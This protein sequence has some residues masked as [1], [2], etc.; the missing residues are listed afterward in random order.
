MF[1][2][3][4]RASPRR[5]S[6][7]KISLP[8]SERWSA[9]TAQGCGPIETKDSWLLAEDWLFILMKKSDDGRVHSS[10]DRAQALCPI[11]FAVYGPLQTKNFNNKKQS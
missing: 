1:R 11:A 9:E 10:F 8:R 5:Y 3:R 6:L 4:Q 7:V 2:A